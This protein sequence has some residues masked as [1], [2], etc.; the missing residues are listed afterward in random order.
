MQKTVNYTS[1][2]TDWRRKRKENNKRKTGLTYQQTIDHIMYL[3]Q[4][5]ADCIE[6]LDAICD[7][8]FHSSNQPK[9]NK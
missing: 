8:E 9:S 6:E 2:L 7:A 1:Q 4:M 5:G 3:T